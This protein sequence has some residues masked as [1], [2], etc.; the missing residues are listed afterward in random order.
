MADL[1]PTRRL[2]TLREAASIISAEYFPISARTLERWPVA[3]K[4]INRKRLGEIDEFRRL[5]QAEIDAAP[6]IHNDRRR[7]GVRLQSVS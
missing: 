7:I 2:V 5:A 3:L 4:V 6:S 1:R